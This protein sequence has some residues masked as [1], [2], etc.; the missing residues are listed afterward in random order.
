[1]SAFAAG[2]DKNLAANINAQSFEMPIKDFWAVSD[3]VENWVSRSPISDFFDENGKY[4]IAY[5]NKEKGI[6]VVMHPTGTPNE[7]KIERAMPLV[8]GV[9]CDSKGSLYV[10]YGCYDEAG[11]GKICTFAIYKYDRSGKYLAKAEYYPNDL[12]WST[13]KAFRLGNCAMAFQGD[14]LICSYAREM[15]NGHQSNAAFCVETATM[16]ENP[17]YYCRTGHSFDQS[18]LAV[19]D[20]TVVFAGAVGY[21]IEIDKY[22]LSDGAYGYDKT[23][24]KTSKKASYVHKKSA[25][26]DYAFSYRVR[27]IT[28]V[29]GVKIYSAWKSSDIIM[30]NLV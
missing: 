2:A 26:S 13:R 6:I 21:E 19:D 4:T 30:D 5:D 10:A 12:N 16:T 15:Y 11:T 1:M 18:V 25:G 3:G 22:V 8:G 23:I 27:A 9:T 29:N 24:I 7:V 20:N 17:V 14:L 28:M